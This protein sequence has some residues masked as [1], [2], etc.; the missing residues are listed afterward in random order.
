[1]KLLKHILVYT[2]IGSILASMVGVSV[3]YH[4]CTTEGHGNMSFFSKA[5]CLCDK[6]GSC[7]MHADTACCTVHD[8][9]EE[10]FETHAF[11][12]TECCYD[13]VERYA[14]ETG[15]VVKD[16]AKLIVKQPLVQKYITK[17]TTNEIIQKVENY[18]KSARNLIVNTYSSAI[19]FVRLMTG[20]LSSESPDEG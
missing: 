12:A 13:L 18:Y 9:A 11:T 7:E 4:F 20:I 5:E 19:Q 6:A 8:K 3:S 10:S 15:F 14:S 17:V 1:M 16:K 2:M